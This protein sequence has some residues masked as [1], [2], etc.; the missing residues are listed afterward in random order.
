MPLNGL[1]RNSN[2]FRWR[3]FLMGR[4]A[5]MTAQFIFRKHNLSDNRSQLESE[6]DGNCE[7]HGDA[8]RPG[9]YIITEW[10]TGY[11][12]RGLD[13]GQIIVS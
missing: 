8:E 5:P 3:S 13:S 12:V 11:M 4:N 9:N 7:N 2:L 6:H 1:N 10:D